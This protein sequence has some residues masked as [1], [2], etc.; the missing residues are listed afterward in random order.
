MHVC[1]CEVAIAWLLEVLTDVCIEN[2]TKSNDENFTW[3]EKVDL[4]FRVCWMT[5]KIAVRSEE[6]KPLVL[7]QAYDH[8]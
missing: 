5:L 1:P 3:Y 7:N 2:N 4:T 8:T 6:S